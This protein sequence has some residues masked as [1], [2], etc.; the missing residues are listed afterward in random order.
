[1]VQKVGLA[2]LAVF[3][4]FLRDA[5]AGSNLVVEAIVGCEDS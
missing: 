3:R 1:M 5:L 2:E 4:Q